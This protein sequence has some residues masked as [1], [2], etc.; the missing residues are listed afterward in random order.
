MATL[1]VED[2]KMLEAKTTDI[3]KPQ[4]KALKKRLAAIIRV[5]GKARFAYIYT[6]QNGKIY[7]IADSEPVDTKDY[8]P[9]GQEYT[10][11]NAEDKQ[12][13]KDGKELITI[14]VPD[15]WG[16]W[17]SALIPIKDSNTGKTIA[18]FGMDFNSKSWDGLLFLEVM[19]SSV[20]FLLLLLA[21]IFLL[22]IG[23]KNKLLKFEIAE[24]NQAEA[25][26][27]ESEE[28]Y[29][30]VFEYS[31][32]GLLYYD[33]SGVIVACNDNFAKIIGSSREKLVGL[34]MLNLP[35][36]KLVA[37]VQRALDGGEGLFEGEYHSVTADKRSSVR[38]LFAPVGVTGGHI[39]GGIGIIENIA[40]RLHAGEVLVQSQER[41][42]KQRN[43]IA[44]IAVD[45]VISFGDLA[46]S[47]HRL[48]EE[49]AAALNVER[50]SIW[51][52]SED[53]TVLECISLFENKTKK[54]SSGT[55]LKYA[56]YPRYFTAIKG[57]SRIYASDAQND[58]RTSEFTEGYLVPHGIASM[59]DAAVQA[60]GDLKG[61]VC[62]EHTA[63][64]RTWH[65]DEESFASTVASIVAQTLANIKRKKAEKEIIELNQELDH[66]VKQ[67]TTE[68]EEA[69]KELETFSYSVSHDL[70]APLRH[71]KGFIDLFL[72]K[73]SAELT[74]EELGYL[75][76]ISGSA[77]NMSLLI[78]AI[79][80]FSRL[81]QTEIRKTTIRS[82]AMVQQVLKYCE[83]D[84]HGR[85]IIFN[86]AALPDVKGDEELIRQVW[87]NLLSNA[88]KYTGKKSEAVVDI[89]ST[90]TEEETTFFVKDNGAGFNMKYA[91]KLFG[92]FQRLH[93]SRD[94]EGVGIGLANVNRIVR[95]HGGTCRAEGETDK[96][97]AFYFSLP[98]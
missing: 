27:R 10:E 62:F 91:E 9:P 67:R 83:P 35:D 57:E 44:R 15:R 60:E 82:N 22:K 94:F 68:L 17:T 5:N 28:K 81:S 66:R 93:K 2:L 98:K 16:T 95:R 92:M 77:T 1:P 79:L 21:F 23:T 65:T 63:E 11:A 13:F 47:F 32:V 70:K 51:L 96:G 3:E 89:G 18:V 24:R 36:K 76:K 74:D 86:V 7:F 12:P 90:S 43:A 14:R 85:N 52:F 75:N 72:E 31:P 20:L 88:I 25:M 50:A 69:N 4:Y 87:T 42:R 73:K 48:T 29:R 84:I 8:S 49:V 46:T 45:E 34:N 55:I 39:Q 38:A 58:P 59:L 80:S 64:K 30:L 61:V 54:H 97:A 6:E 40:E 19:Q 26:L 41:A 33:Q 56:D 71:I 37:S 53:K 78:D